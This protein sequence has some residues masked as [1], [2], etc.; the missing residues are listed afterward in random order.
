M[1]AV[2][3]YA[4]TMK[5]VLIA[6]IVLITQ[7]FWSSYGTKEPLVSKKSKL[8][9]NEQCDEVL[10]KAKVK[11]LMDSTHEAFLPLTQDDSID[12]IA[13]KFSDRTDLMEGVLRDG[14]RGNFYI[15]AIDIGPYVEFL[16]NAITMK[17][18]MREI[19]QDRA[20]VGS[21]KL[22]GTIRADLHLVRD[23]NVQ[24]TR[25]A[26]EQSISQP[27]LLPLPDL[28]TAD[29]G[30]H[31][32]DHG[33]A[34]VHGVNLNEVGSTDSEKFRNVRSGEASHFHSGTLSASSHQGAANDHI[35][36]HG[37]T[38]SE[39]V[40]EQ[41]VEKLSPADNQNSIKS[42]PETVKV[43]SKMD[44]EVSNL[45]GQDQSSL[46]A[47]VAEQVE[48]LSVTSVEKNSLEKN[49]D[50]KPLPSAR[51][52]TGY[53]IGSSQSANA[54]SA[55]SM[56]KNTF[57]T[58]ESPQHEQQ[59]GTT[60][61][62][63]TP[64]P[65]TVTTNPAEQYT[66]VAHENGKKIS[67]QR[68]NPAVPSQALESVNE[69]IFTSVP[70]QYVVDRYSSS[71]QA[72]TVSPSLASDIRVTDSNVSPDLVASVAS[73][74]SE[75]HSHLDS[76]I[77]GSSHTVE[78]Q[79]VAISDG[80]ISMKE[81]V[82][83]SSSPTSLQAS[84]S[85]EDRP[86]SDSN[87]HGSSPTMEKLHGTISG[88]AISM[89]EAVLPSSSPPP[90]QYCTL[91]DCIGQ[92][93]SDDS[94][95]LE[96][97][98]TTDH[99]THHQSVFDALKE[100]NDCSH[101]G[102]GLIAGVLRSLAAVIRSVPFLDDVDDA[103]IAFIINIALLI[104]AIVFHIIW[105]FLS[106]FDDSFISDRMVSHDLATK[107]KFL[108]EQNKVKDMEINRL[109]SVA[110]RFQGGFEESTEL[111]KELC[112]KKM[113]IENHVK[114]SECMRC[115]LEEER[116]MRVCLESDLASERKNAVL[117]N[118]KASEIQRLLDDSER[119][120]SYTM[121]ELSST[122]RALERLENNLHDERQMHEATVADFKNAKDTVLK[123]QV[124][125]QLA[126]EEIK[127][128]ELEKGNFEL[129][130]ATLSSMIEEIERNR[131]EGSAGESGGSGGWSDFGDDITGEG[132]DG[133][134][135]TSA[136]STI[137]VPLTSVMNAND[138]RET[139]KLRVQLKKTEQEFDST[140]KALEGEIEE[141]R[142][143][144]SKLMAVDSELE[145][146]KREVEERER[147]RSRADE[148][149][150]ELLAIMKD[151]NTKAREAESL[152]DKLRDEITALQ[153]ELCSA[154]EDKSKKEE[155]IIELE[156]EL[157]R[158]RNNQLKLETKRFNEVIEL[159]RKLDVLQANQSLTSPGQAYDSNQSA[160]SLERDLR[161][162]TSMWEEAPH[163]M[164]RS[165][166][167]P[168][169]TIFHGISNRKS[170]KGSVRVRRSDIVQRGHS[171]SKEEKH[172]ERKEFA[173]R[174]VRS[175]S[176]GRQFWSGCA[177][178]SSSRYVALE[179]SRPPISYAEFDT[180]PI[181]RRHSRS[182]VVYYSSGGS[183]GGRS[184]PPEMP[185][186]SAV[187][188][189]GVKKPTGKRAVGPSLEFKST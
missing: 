102:K 156:S 42:E 75:D 79:H 150:N 69:T 128:L 11:R 101:A 179:P 142:R 20:D 134:E 110:D 167:K 59:V 162:P 178:D 121:N 88:D 17:K 105:S 100:S 183:N 83:P 155:K 114:R 53:I 182:N 131:K 49:V 165:C 126:T 99:V 170:E 85:P 23:Y 120:H 48:E 146:K 15:S 6:Q 119:A 90:V 161:S 38:S 78:K 72:N 73:L 24:V 4:T 187:P 176:N 163:T 144:E 50:E 169:E 66:S 172:R 175:R 63:R 82:L 64:Q 125:L 47:S 166:A 141:R 115:E 2:S 94:Q 98:Q 186:L 151:N 97:A 10:F 174:R 71:S 145:R 14:R 33:A 118:E 16:R 44:S 109:S 96:S 160:S 181:S 67:T 154:V 143:L 133:K 19:S 152:R 30:V 62:L 12:V 127:K 54:K 95:R 86:H 68:H 113:E 25:Y 138:I 60:E 22:L 57:S 8:C 137:T 1:L 148:R 65:V 173:H 76:N 52:S 184:P 5:I 149:C 46:E 140:K 37:E 51:L 157:K 3:S 45:M 55:S 107:C 130:N 13:V 189:P 92:H 18:E 103:E 40:T 58:S 36:S 7:I 111:R 77:Q 56:P 29:L 106:D 21:K 158:M 123:L 28:T 39:Q 122:R 112:L 139:A 108:D 171:P 132:E 104:S 136:S 159:K 164:N 135:R 116:K 93:S 31:G 35:H 124:E 188:P 43:I 32:H 80:G 84:L 91:E 177:A 89:K 61:G 129:E 180:D 9:G 41:S 168:Y 74:S 147:D 70:N 81:A 87:I 153:R 34:G 26:E 27:E 185:L 117:A